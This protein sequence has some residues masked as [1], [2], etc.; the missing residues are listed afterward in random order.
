M[1][2][3]ATNKAEDKKKAFKPK[4]D[5]QIA[6]VSNN[7]GKDASFEPLSANTLSV[8]NVLNTTLL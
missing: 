3:K 6:T 1:V 5:L 8:P 2:S 7:S 4:P